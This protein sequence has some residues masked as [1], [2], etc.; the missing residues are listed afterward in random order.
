MTNEKSFTTSILVDQSPEEVFKAINNVRGWWSEEIEG[1]T[2]KLN[3]EFYYHYKDIHRCWLKVVELNP[4][5]KVVWLVLNNYF[6]FTK[7]DT[8]WKGTKIVFE[9][10]RKAKQTELKFTHVG[11]VPAYECYS[12]CFDAWTNYIQNSLFRLITS[13]QGKPITKQGN[14]F[15]NSGR[16]Y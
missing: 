7:D 16:S 2:N 11:L 13:G 12:A 4:G 10:S 6:N 8:E 1:I 15:E 14:E 3:E 5:D 9:I